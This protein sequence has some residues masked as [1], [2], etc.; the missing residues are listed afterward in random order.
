MTWVSL[1]LTDPS[2]NLRLLVLRELLGYPPDDDEVLE[3]EMIREQD[4]VVQ[5]LLSLQN[6]DGSFRTKDGMGD[7]WS[8][9]KTTSQALVRLG[10]L[11]FTREY[12]AIQKA[13]DFLFRHQLKDGSWPIP[14]NETDDA[15]SVIPLQTGLP[16]RGL[17]ACGYATD[18]R[19]EKAYD[20]LIR[21]G[22]P[23]GGW[24]GGIKSEQYVFPAGYRRLPH[25]KYGCRSTTSF[26][27]SALALHPERRVSGE[28]RRGLDLLLAQD[29]LQAANM[30]HEIAKITGKEKDRGYFTYFARYDIAF[31][32]D[33]CWK[34]GASLEDERVSAMV[35]FVKGLQSEYGLW[36]Y[37]AHPEA[38]R[39]LSF[40]LLRSLARIDTETDWIS[41]QPVTPFQ[42]Y[43]KKPRR[44]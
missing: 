29:A 2:P 9:I 12:P 11:G 39:W 31:I 26:A 27:V 4:P 22:L 41:L 5:G 30:G 36:E 16:L 25:S 7:G 33:L 8:G 17:A 18:P 21:Q 23:E 40:D 34:V 42:T 32:L 43:P 3:L 14:K 20:W 10:Y 1:L 6:T 13:V 37:P 15:Y 35:E 44:Y 38:S 24:P 28:A 19:S